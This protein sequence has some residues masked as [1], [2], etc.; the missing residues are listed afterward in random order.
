MR[1]QLASCEP[2]KLMHKAF[3][4]QTPIQWLVTL[5]LPCAIRNLGANRLA[6]QERISILSGAQLYTRRPH[7]LRCKLVPSSS[8][9]CAAL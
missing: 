1:T 9:L 4:S 3:S 6:F 2:T 8:I 7:Y 5:I